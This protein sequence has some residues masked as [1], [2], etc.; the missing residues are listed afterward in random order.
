MA[1]NKN[2]KNAISGSNIRAGGNIL[3]GDVHL[4]EHHGIKPESNK[5]EVS[6]PFKKLEKLLSTGK[7]R[8]AI[9]GLADFSE[10]QDPEICKDALLLS[11]RW[12]AMSRKEQRGTLSAGELTLER[13]QISS[14]FLDL[15]ERF[16][17]SVK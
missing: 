11:S 1:V 3:I 9:R 2:N 8:E 15:L 7:V 4:H 16:R 17:Q 13:N 6:N 14:H 10:N 5:D 12:E